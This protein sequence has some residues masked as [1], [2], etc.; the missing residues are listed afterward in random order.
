[1]TYLKSKAYSE[2]CETSTIKRFAKIVNGYNYFHELLLFLQ[3]FPRSLLHEMNI[4][5]Y[6]LQRYSMLKTAGGT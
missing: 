1:M 5:R 3:S 4:L 2:N 6:F